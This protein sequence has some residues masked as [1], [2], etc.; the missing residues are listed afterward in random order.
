MYARADI[1][2]SVDG[3]KPPHHVYKNVVSSQSIQIG[4]EIDPVGPDLADKE[5]DGHS[6]KEKDAIAVKIS[7]VGEKKVDTHCEDVC[8]PCK[9]RYYEILAKGY[10]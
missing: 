1:C 4:T 9:I 8:K 10:F 7:A 6:R 3:V 2:G 5:A